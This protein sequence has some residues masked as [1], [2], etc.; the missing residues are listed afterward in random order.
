MTDGEW[1]GEVRQV[2]KS[3]DEVVV[4]GSWT[5]VRDAADR[6]K[7]ILAI[8]EDVTEKKRLE[9]QMI[10]AQRM[11]SI[12][13]LAGGIAHDLNN[14][15]T[16]ILMSVDHLKRRVSDE[17]SKDTLRVIASSAQRGAE[18]LSQVLSFARGMEGQSMPVSISRLMN[19]LARIVQDTFP[20][21]IELHL[22]TPP[23]EWMLSGDS[24]QIHQVLLNLCVNARDAMPAGGKLTVDT[25]S[26]TID[27]QYATMNIEAREGPHIVIGV[28]DEGLGIPPHVLPKIFDPFFTTK[29]PGKG[30][31]LGL[32]TSLA[33]VK[34]HGGFIRVRSEP[35]HGTRFTVYLPALPHATERAPDIEEQPLPRGNNELVLVIDDEAAVREITRQTLGA[36]GYRTLLAADGAEAVTLYSK[37]STEIAVVL[38]DMAMPVMDGA[39]T[40]QV[41][42]KMNP[43]VRIIA[44]SGVTVHGGMKKTAEAGARQFLPKPYTAETILRALR[45]VLHEE[46]T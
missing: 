25:T 39:T 29:P 36:Y 5:L 10:R 28:E 27:S 11:E 6:P 23:E 46:N 12:G 8:N 24:T 1:K 32:S 22:Q 7:C 3:G 26:V 31:G 19:E 20:K 43:Q 9:D 37:N 21:N 2:T 38:T 14:V 44:A 45:Q 41:L 34:S 40:I 17:S 13:T 18:M 42:M 33:I 15:L 35:G 4:E 16:P 30:T